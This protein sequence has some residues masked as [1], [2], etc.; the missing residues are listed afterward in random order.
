MYQDTQDIS[1]NDL[2]VYGIGLMC[3]SVC[4]T[5]SD[6]EATEQLNLME[7]TGIKAGWVISEDKNFRTGEANPCPCELHPETRRHILFNC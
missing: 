5:L 6:D 7:P 1:P 3:A 2:I 4:T